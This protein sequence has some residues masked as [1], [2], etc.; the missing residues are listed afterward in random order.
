ME[1]DFYGTGEGYEIRHK[2]YTGD[3]WKLYKQVFLLI[4]AIIKQGTYQENF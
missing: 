4:K 1:I 3:A 2:L